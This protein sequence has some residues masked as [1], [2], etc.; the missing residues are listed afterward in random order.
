[1]SLI[2]LQRSDCRLFIT[3]VI[4]I[5]L[6]CSLELWLRGLLRRLL[7]RLAPMR[8]RKR[9]RDRCLFEQQVVWRSILRMQ[10]GRELE[11]NPHHTFSNRHLTLTATP[12]TQQLAVLTRRPGELRLITFV[13]H[14]RHIHIFVREQ[15]Q[16]DPLQVGHEPGNSLLPHTIHQCNADVAQPLPNCRVGLEVDVWAVCFPAGFNSLL[17]IFR[18]FPASFG[19]CSLVLAI[20]HQFFSCVQVP[21]DFLC[22]WQRGPSRSCHLQQD[23]LHFITQGSWRVDGKICNA[24]DK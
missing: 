5:G 22:C 8:R 14:Q 16:I 12:G 23:L 6:I 11:G 19:R 13:G 21:V 3:L 18:N 17:Q 4:D 7:L 1:M 9:V 2:L 20:V 24:R 15:L 10:N